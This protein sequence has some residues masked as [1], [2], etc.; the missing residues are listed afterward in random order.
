MNF[1]TLNVRGLGESYRRDWVARL[2][3]KHNL[4]LVCLQETQLGSSLQTA[5]IRHC[6]GDDHCDFDYVSANGRVGGILTIWSRSFF[7]VS[8]VIKAS[9][10]VAFVNVYG[11]QANANK[12]DS[13]AS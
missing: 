9:G 5:A 1:M 11:P 6:W 7:S 2:R 10:E 8:H 4:A 13:G 3:R 12:V